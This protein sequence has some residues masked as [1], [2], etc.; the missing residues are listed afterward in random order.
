MGLAMGMTAIALIY[1]PWGR[2]SGAHLNPATTFSFWLLGKIATWD[3]AFYIAA[4]FIGGL[5]GVGMIAVLLEERFTLPPVRMIVTIPGANGPVLAF[6]A[7]SLLSFCTMVVVLVMTNTPH[8]ARFTGL[9]VGALI[10]A[11]ITF[12][13]PL[14]GF[15]MNPARTLASALPA[16]T[17]NS[18]WIYFSAPLLGMLTAAVLYVRMAG[19]GRI[20]CAKLQHDDTKRCIFCAFRQNKERANSSAQTSNLA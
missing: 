3:A 7:E 10:V 4:Q 2:Q 15:S 1:S 17:W 6:V 19:L 14:S 12:E 18:I 8:L 13:A 5:A 9:A 11:Y 16:N 20:R